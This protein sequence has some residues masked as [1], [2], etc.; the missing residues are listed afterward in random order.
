MGTAVNYFLQVHTSIVHAMACQ[1]KSA[2]RKKMPLLYRS[3]IYSRSE[4]VSEE[5]YP[6]IQNFNFFRLRPEFLANKFFINC[7]FKYLE[8]KSQTMQIKVMCK[9]KQQIL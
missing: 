7:S 8:N 6:S 1:H 9:L 3:A 5:C 4:N 2:D